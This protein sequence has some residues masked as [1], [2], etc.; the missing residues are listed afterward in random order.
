MIRLFFAV[1][2]LVIFT[3][4]ESW[5]D[6]IVDNTDTEVDFIGS[7][8]GS[9]GNT[10]YPFYGTT[11]SYSLTGSGAD[12][13]VYSFEI[14]EAGEYEVYAWW[15]SHS[16]CS[17][18][19]P[20]HIY[21]S[22]EAATVRVN[23]RENPGQWNYLASGYFEQGVHEIV[24]TDDANGVLVVA[25]AVR[26]VPIS[27]DNN[28]P[29]LNTIGNQTVNEGEL[30]EF[31]VSASDPDDNDLTY[32]AANLPSG[33]A[34]DPAS[35]TFSWTPEYGQAGSYQVLFSVSDNGS[36]IMSDSEEITITVGDVN[37][38]PVLNTIG[39]RTVSEGELL[40]FVVSATDPDGDDL[41]Y[42]AANLPSGAA[43]DPASQTFSWIPEY[44]QFGNYQVLFSVS[45][46]GSPIMSDSEEITITV[47]DVN[48]TPVL[49]T[50]G[51]RSVNEG[52]L[53]EFVVSATDPD[54]DDLT[55][56]AANLP[57]G[58]AFDPASQT[59]SWTPG[60]DQV[61]NYQ[62]LFSVS[63]D[64]S[65]IMSDSEEI[66]ITVGDVNR[67]PVLN[68]IGN[69]TVSEG[70]LLEFVV[71]AT[72]PDGD[73]LTYEAANLPSSAS[74]DPATQTFLWTPGYDQVGNYQVL[75][76]VSDDGSP[77][78]SDS[79]EIT[80][81]VGDVNRPPVLNTIGNRTVSEGELL[82]FVVSA[83]DPDGDDL[84]YE[85]SDLPSGAA[86]DP[87]SQTFSWTPEYGQAGSY[88][89]LFSVFDNGSPILSD[90][91]EITISV[92]AEAADII[93]DNTDTEVDF[94]GSDWDSNGNTIYPF[95]GTTF[96]YSLTGSGADEAVYSFEITE[97]GEYEVYAWWPSHSYCSTDTP[98]HIYFSDEAAT[99]RV[100]QR[101]NPGQ[102]NYLASGYF[103]QG[104]HEIVITDD[105][106][107]VLVVADA[108]R[109]VPIPADN[110]A[111]VLNPIGNQSVNEGELLEFVVS[112]TDL[113]GDDLT[114]EAADLPTGA[115]FDTTTQTFS[116]TP[117]FGQAGSF[118]VIFSVS[119]NGSPVMTDSEEITIAVGNVNQAPVLNPI[120]NQSVNEGELLEFVVSATDPDGDDLNYEAADLPTGASFDTTTQTFSWTPEFGQAGS[121]QVIF[122]VSDN[123]SPVMTDSEEI[124]IAVGN[125]NQ[126]PV[127]NPIG[128]QSVNEGELL[129]FVVSAT[130]PDGDDLNYEAA[131]LP[132]GASFDTTTQTFSW[133]PEFGQA[134]SFQVI[135]SVSD[136]GSPVM[137]DSEEITIAV[138]NV[139]QAPVLNPIGNQSVNEGEL[140]EFVVSATDPDGDDL[141]YEAADLPTG[142]SFD[143]TTQTFSWTPEF[144][145]AG[146]FQVIFSVS[147]NGSPVMTDS[148]EITIAVGN[149]N[150]AP[151]LNPIG[152]QSV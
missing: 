92:R 103:E 44:G 138:G 81:T 18:D 57:S 130:D 137:T 31:A 19:T 144:G 40:E 17:T 102:W 67:P 107:G 151:V 24:I 100:N 140:L 145:Q 42:E 58:A 94:V 139:N 133:T 33:A 68:T 73:D 64:G 20:Y 134:G 13:A 98:Y 84:T 88:Q 5:A 129:E 97:A 106:N 90:A 15:P 47:G 77:I 135:F 62:V 29:I 46:D 96:S 11:F 54:G 136:N 87:A 116:W 85:A 78:M 101:E 52:Q 118:Q 75:F 66:T 49:N 124:T 131:D 126:A 86:F 71:S 6:I 93:I 32:E 109:L 72:D 14:T 99:V 51:N 114:Y 115:S 123:G 148:E 36:P 120:G 74:F 27:P 4:A 39:N 23:Q 7:D 104:V 16:Y 56:E 69:R 111:P 110:K 30:L 48:L 26:L 41:T 147:D 10:I 1:T 117:E 82:E 143:T 55:Y 45:D 79:E 28:A 21:F 35:Q 125:V 60:Y 8:W 2:F 38:P 152:N 43:F 25:D 95:Y 59:F 149:V 3:S 122:S 22:D 91:E 61:G 50:I 65:P 128:N 132:T 112:A 83:T 108:V 70:E 37:R 113:D 34:F 150:Q 80:I 9:N 12:E 119:D 121:F 105:A 142:A 127:L 76:S 53:L 146:S 63:D 141:N 89:V